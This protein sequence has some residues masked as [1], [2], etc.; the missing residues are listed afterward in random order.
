MIFFFFSL[1]NRNSAAIERRLS[2]YLSEQNEERKKN[3]TLKV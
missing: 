3:E 1:E 2:I